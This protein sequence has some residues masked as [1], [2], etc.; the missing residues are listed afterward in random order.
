MALTKPDRDIIDIAAGMKAGGELTIAAGAITLVENAHGVDTEADAASDDLDTIAAGPVPDGAMVLLHAADA[1]RT[2]VLKHGTGNIQIQGGGDIVLDAAGKSVLLRRDGANFRDVVTAA[3]S[4][5]VVQVVNMQTG[6][7]A[8]GTTLVP[9]DDTIPLN[10]E[11]V[12]YMALSITPT[13]AGNTLIIDIVIISSHSVATAT[14]FASLFQD[15]AAG[16]LATAA[17]EYTNDGHVITLS[18]RHKMIAGTA[19]PTTF[20]V[21][22]GSN[23]AGTTTFNGAVGTRRFGGVLASSITITEIAA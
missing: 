12:E 16:A 7:A 11:G 20:K 15:A 10:T 5:G 8:T 3:P 22:M 14:G 13:A 2:V 19:N 23:T 1:A 6:A 17:T 9:N 21:R 18:F 4:G